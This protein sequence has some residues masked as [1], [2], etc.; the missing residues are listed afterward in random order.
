MKKLII[1]PLIIVTGI[2]AFAATNKV[3][4]AKTMTVKRCQAVRNGLQCVDQAQPGKDYCWKH[5][6]FAKAV[7]EM[8]E[9]ASDGMGRAWNATKGGATNAWEATKGGAKKVWQGT[10]DVA[11]DARVGIIELFGGKDAKEKK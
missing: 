2:V 11:D 5:R 3:E 9:D 8:A 1:A 4:V 7:G 10:K 6:G